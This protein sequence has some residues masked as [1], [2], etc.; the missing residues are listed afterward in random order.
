MRCAAACKT[1]SL[2]LRRPLPLSLMLQNEVT[3]SASREQ[4]A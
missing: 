4:A 3:H 1:R 2:A